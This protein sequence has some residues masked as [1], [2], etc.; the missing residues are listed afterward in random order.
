MKIRGVNHVCLVVRNR[1]ASEAF[2]VG[3]MGLRR[4]HKIESWFVLSAETT[5][6]LVEIPEV[7]PTDSLF[8]QIQHF[9][10]Q[11]DSLRSTYNTLLEAGLKPFQMDFSGSVRELVDKD[12]PLDFGLGSIFVPDPDENL[13]E[14]LEEGRGIFQVDMR[15]RLS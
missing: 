2:F 6:H 9:A 13:I 3:V 8:H 11:V 4:H 15:P 1:K 12:D 7:E 5:L 10:V 14:F